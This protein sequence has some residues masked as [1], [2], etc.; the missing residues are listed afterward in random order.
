MVNYQAEIQPSDGRSFF[1]ADDWRAKG[2]TGEASSMRGAKAAI[3]HW[4][5]YG[6][7]HWHDETAACDG[8]YSAETPAG[9]V[10]ATI[11]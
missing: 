3:A 2:T 4:A 9:T 11:N 6:R 7:L 10:I 8:S 1:P 5:G